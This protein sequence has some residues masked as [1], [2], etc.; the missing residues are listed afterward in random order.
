MRDG[1]AECQRPLR[2]DSQPW[3]NPIYHPFTSSQEGIIIIPT[4]CDPILLA[5]L[6]L[7][8]GKASVIVDSFVRVRLVP[9]LRRC[10]PPLGDA[11]VVWLAY[12]EQFSLCKE[13][14]R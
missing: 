4:A 9:I 5:A 10:Y 2:Q 7:S 11:L 8:S 6:G 1:V 3:Q 13:T 12:L 14:V